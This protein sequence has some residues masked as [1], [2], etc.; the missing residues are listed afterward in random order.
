MPCRR[1]KERHANA[2]KKKARYTQRHHAEEIRKRQESL[3]GVK[4]F[5]YECSFCQ[6]Y[7]LSS[8]R[9]K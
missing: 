8:Q 3:H 9:D 4:L 6:G 1:V 2:C 5:V 7:H